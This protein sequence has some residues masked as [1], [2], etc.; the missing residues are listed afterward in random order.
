MGISTL[1]VGIT[2][3]IGAGKSLVCK[4]FS[5]LGAPVYDADMRAK[6]LMNED[7][8][9]IRQISE[10]FGSECYKNGQLD[11]DYL[12]QL[13]FKNSDLLHH[14][15]QLVHPRVAEDTKQWVA[16]HYRAPYVIKEAALLIESGAYKELDKLVVVTAPLP[17]R[18][19]RVLE[20]DSFRSKEQVEQIISRQLPEE[21][22]T[23]QADYLIHND[24]STLVI[25]QVL[26]LHKRFITLFRQ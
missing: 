15:N 10:R 19:Q 18:V 26:K 11:R 23:K 2:G 25:P 21:E 12:S 8:T 9:L 16:L 7:P 14:L 22:K 20:R 5:V 13:V 4:I 6:Q 17:L 3:G 1:R 24:E